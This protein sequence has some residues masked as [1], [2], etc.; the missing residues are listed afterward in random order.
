MQIHQFHGVVAYGDAIGN[1]ILSL[2]RM[3]RKMGHTSEIFSEF[4]Q[5]NFEN[6]T[7]PYV[8][9]HKFSSADNVLLCHFSIGYSSQ[10]LAWLQSVP[11]YKVIIYH[12]ITPPHYFAGIS[13]TFYEKTH[14]GRDQLGRLCPLTQA[15][16][17]DSDFNRLELVQLG[18]QQT[19]VLPIIFEPALYRVR[20]DKTVLRRWDSTEG[21]KVLFVGRLVPNKKYEDLILTFYYLKQFEPQAR[22]FLVGLTDQ[23]ESYLGYLQALIER[24]G[25]RDVVFTGHVSRK[26]LAAYYRAADVYLSMSEHEGFGAPLLESMYFGVPVIAYEAAA[27]PETL[28]DAGILVT[29]KD[30]AVIAELVSLLAHD[31]KLRTRILERQRKRWLAFT[32]DAL[33]PHLQRCLDTIR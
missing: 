15:G 22:L 33:M 13:E 14:Q 19:A 28:G 7:R 27:I 1:Q 26:E 29:R 9:Y 12:N 21:P 2:Q 25:L 8:K 5:H 6:K 16:W 23:M 24:L 3:L 10:V 31:G 32:P 20:P 17:G 30:H 18:W 11:D 4:A